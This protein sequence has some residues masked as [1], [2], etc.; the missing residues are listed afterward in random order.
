MMNTQLAIFDLDG[1]LIDSK[2]LHFEALNEALRE[3]GPQFE[4]SHRDHSTKYDGLSTKRK[5]EI[6]NLEKG[7]P[8]E[9]FESVWKLKQD[10]TVRMLGEIEQDQEL[11]SFMDYLQDIGLK[12]AVASNSVRNT[13]DI[14]LKNLGINNYFSLILSNE[15]VK[16]PKPH[17]EI[18]WKTMMHFGVV[19][20]VTV[21]FEDSYVGRLAA[22]RSGARL[23]PIDNRK[24]LTWQKIRSVEVLSSTLTPMK[25]P[26]KSDKL[27][28]L[29]PMAGAGS[30]FEAAGYTFPKPLIEV[31]GKPMI[32]VVVEN[33][34]IE[35]RFIYIVQRS[36]YEK[37]NLEFL[38][39]LITPNCEIV[40]IDG[41]TEGAACT[42]LLAREFIDNDDSLVIAN[43][44]QF[45]EW[46]SGETLYSFMA[47]G[48]DGGIVTFNAT[49]PKWSYARIDEFGLVQEVAEKK[50]ISNIAT[51]GIYFWK[52]GSDYVKYADNMIEKNIRT[53]GEFYVCP[54]FNQAIEDGKK[55]RI[56]NIDQMWGLGTPEDLNFFLEHHN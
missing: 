38:L 7:F 16:S 3:F 20:D 51:V 11:V 15:D 8:I 54:V 12:L 28:V 6:L 9:H 36:H 31:R 5:L 23:I 14:V 30:R 13:I 10:I 56:R 45:V 53:N 41:L 46:N 27:N 22:Q 40:Q 25:T 18:Y 47:D 35:A 1:V 17:P 2:E 52:K 21:I 4:I 50:P 55:F 19:P 44:D 43:S 49:H 34:N 29:I 26:W 39:K 24:D 33:L 37:Y 42:T 48:I 32:Q